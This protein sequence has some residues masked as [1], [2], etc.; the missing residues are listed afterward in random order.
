MV[1]NIGSSEEDYLL[2]KLKYFLNYELSSSSLFFISFVYASTFVLAIIAAVVFTPFLIYVLYRNRKY[3]WLILFFALIVFPPLIIY[4]TN[5]KGMF[6]SVVLYIELGLFYF[7]CFVLRFVVADWVE[8]M[9]AR[10]F[11]KMCEAEK[12]QNKKL[13]E[14]QFGSSGN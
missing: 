6:L 2:E 9:K 10:A 12:E 5:I 1:L 13:F 14:Q 11:R 3:L 8:D 7:Y 4:L